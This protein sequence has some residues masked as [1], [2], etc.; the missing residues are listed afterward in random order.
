MKTTQINFFCVFIL[1]FSSF[2]VRA[3]V[4]TQESWETISNRWGSVPFEQLKQ[5][6]TTNDVNA[7]YYLAIAYS[8]GNGISQDDS[9]AFKWMQM[10]ARQGLA[11]AQRKLGWM[12]QNGTGTT[13]SINQAVDWYKKAAASGDTQAEI[14]L[15]WIYAKGAY[16]EGAVHGQGVEAQINSG[17]IVPNHDLA[18]K[19]ICQAVDTNSMDGQYQVANLLYDE[20]D[21]AGQ[22][23]ITRFPLAA[24]W[25]AKA[26]DQGYDK[27]QYQLAEMYNNGQL[28]DDQ[29]SNCIP[30][31][32]KAAAQG[33]DEAKAEVGELSTL[34]PN[35]EL[36]KSVKTIEPLQQSAENGNLAAQYQLARRYQFGIG[37]PQDVSEA[38]KRMQKAAQNEDQDNVV[39]DAKYYLALMYEKGQGTAQDL[40]AARKLFI[41]AASPT[42]NGSQPDAAVRVGQMYEEGD[43]VPQDDHKAV[44]IYGGF[45]HNPDLTNQVEYIVVRNEGI[46]KL[47][48]LWSQGRGFPD[49]KEKTERGYREPAGLINY[50]QGL[51]ATGKAEFYVGQIFYQGKLVPQDLVEAAARFKIAANENLDGAQKIFEQIESGFSPDKKA[52]EQKRYDELEQRFNQAKQIVIATEEAHKVMPW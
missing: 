35:S 45:Y 28:G 12:F 6:A 41:A 24:E 36:L 44:E 15:A 17:G 33:N 51:I 27:A 8:T 14:N 5:A 47:L 20:V 16:G 32:L 38:F 18:E 1:L 42:I 2:L 43:G 9:E 21:K 46:E 50:W 13:N 26:A 30:W 10:A 39:G 23:D 31:Y 29:R 25:F 49:E 22:Q 3:D 7:Q 34:Y 4:V 40:L 11:W 52:A 48:N 19:L 37:V